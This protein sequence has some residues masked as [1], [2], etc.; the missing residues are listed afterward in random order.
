[1]GSPPSAFRNQAAVAEPLVSGL[2]VVPNIEG[3]QVRDR[4]ETEGERKTCSLV[5]EVKWSFICIR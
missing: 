5:V 1:M 3:P 2:E 4:P